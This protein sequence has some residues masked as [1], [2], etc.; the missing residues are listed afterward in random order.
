MGLIE[1]LRRSAELTGEVVVLLVVQAGLFKIRSISVGSDFVDGNE[2]W[3]N[4]RGVR[5]ALGIVGIGALGNLQTICG[6]IPV[7]VEKKGVGAWVFSTYERPAGVL[8]C[9]L[10]SV[11]IRVRV[12][13]IRAI[14]DLYT[15][16]EPVVI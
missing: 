10:N 1:G 6:T 7:G 13:G 2:G 3:L 5:C 9:V 16:E 4:Q 14:A 15:V 12:E 8:Q 11:S